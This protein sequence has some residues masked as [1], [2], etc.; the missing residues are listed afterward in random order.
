[1]IAYALFT[2]ASNLRFTAAVWLIYLAAHGYSPLAIGLF[3]MLFHLTK[4]VAEVPTGAFADL[5][6]RRASLIA[7]CVVGA[8]AE[9]LFLA[10]SPWIIA[11][12]LALSGLSYAFRGGADTALLWGL[13]GD[14][15]GA[16]IAADFSQVYSRMFIVM[17]ITEALGVALGGAMGTLLAG[18]PFVA[19]SAML[20]LALVPL[21][22]LPEQRGGASARTSPLAHVGEGIRAAW[23]DPILLGLLL[24]S[25]LLAGVFATV[26]MYSQLFFSGLGFSE[27]AIG[28][29]FAVTVLPNALYAGLSPRLLARVSRR[30][31]LGGCVLA[32]SLGLLIMRTG[33]PVLVVPAFVLLFY[34]TDSLVMPAMSRYLNERAPEAQRAT[35]LS[36]DTGLFSATMIV[37][38]PLFGLGLT[39]VS[40]A[41]AFG[42]VL[43]ALAGGSAAIGVVMVALLRRRVPSSVK[44]AG[45]HAS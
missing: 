34:A 13:S 41:T 45:N 8:V 27:A 21:V 6:G 42:W 9:L 11:L 30:W 26:S 35:V 28:V 33:A 5:V 23:A 32:E 36:L 29:I 10:P 14:V 19:Q 22:R 3:E 40:F 38:F 7:A 25:G 37:L 4:F 2:A 18:L 15:D 17:L 20:A 39:H 24:L 31:L 16:N 1:M 12:S 43:I 44:S